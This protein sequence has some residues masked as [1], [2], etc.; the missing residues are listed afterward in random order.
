[1]SEISRSIQIIKQA[2]KIADYTIHTVADM[3]G[4]YSDMTGSYADVEKLSW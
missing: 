2:K 4:P 1:M 3:V